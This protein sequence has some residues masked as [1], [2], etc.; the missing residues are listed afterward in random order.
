MRIRTL[1]A[2]AVMAGLAVLGGAGQAGAH[3]D[4]IVFKISALGDG[5]TRAAATWA[6]DND[7]VTDKV[8]AT[9]SAT[10]DDGRTVGPWKLEAVAGTPGTFTTALALPPG[11]W[12]VTV[13]SGFPALGRGQADLTVTAVPG[14]TA[15]E[16]GTAGPAVP[17]SSA[18]PT[19]TPAAVAETAD[20]ADAGPNWVIAVAA[21]LAAVAAVV[22]SAALLRR[23]RAAR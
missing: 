18:A 17:P 6:N 20:S 21:V 23:R 4:T 3:G 2:A 8:A 22:V 13:E 10:A 1:A 5:H 14:T 9:L 19:G 16:G 12:A 7:P 15:G 11:H